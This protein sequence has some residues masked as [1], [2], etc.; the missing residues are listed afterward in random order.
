[1]RILIADDHPVV[2]HGLKQI[3]AAQSDMTVVGEAKNGKETRRRCN[4]THA[5]SPSF[6]PVGYAATIILGSGK[7]RG[8][9]SQDAA[10]LVLASL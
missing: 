8:E 3:L 4:G 6:V 5:I 9:L 10:R 2:R 1:M 7:R